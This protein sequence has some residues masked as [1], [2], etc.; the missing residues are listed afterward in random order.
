MKSS[1]VLMRSEDGDC[2]IA[3]L[4]LALQLVPTNDLKELSNYGQASGWGL[5]VSSSVHTNPLSFPLSLILSCC[6]CD[7]V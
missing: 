6:L 7:P 1:N 5:G 2:V 4:G 3:D